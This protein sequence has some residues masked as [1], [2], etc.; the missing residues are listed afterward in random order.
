MHWYEFNILHKSNGFLILLYDIWGFLD[1]DFLAL[2]FFPSEPDYEFNKSKLMKY[3]QMNFAGDAVSTQTEE[4]AE[5][6]LRI[7]E[8]ESLIGKILSFF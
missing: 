3:N 4:E 2:N 8:K 1:G 5:E 6:M 7:V